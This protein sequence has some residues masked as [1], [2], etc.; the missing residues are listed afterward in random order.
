MTR[1]RWPSPP[2]RLTHRPP[3][4]QGRSRAAPLGVPAELRWEGALGDGGAVAWTAGFGESAATSVMV[5][6]EEACP[7][8]ASDVGQGP[9][10]EGLSPRPSVPHG[11][12]RSS[13]SVV[14]QVVWKS[15]TQKGLTEYTN[16]GL[17][18]RAPYGPTADSWDWFSV[19]R[20]RLFLPPYPHPRGS[21]DSLQR[22]LRRGPVVSQ[23]RRM[24]A[25]FEGTEFLERRQLCFL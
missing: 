16:Q 24:C 19:G 21:Q 1:T 8:W 20:G 6:G 22:A 25:S 7:A 14:G 10:G 5:V 9:T 23:H 3:R 13:F 17:H 2:L 15:R 18:L 4:S 11:E 12:S